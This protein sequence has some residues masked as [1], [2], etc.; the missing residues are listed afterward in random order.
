MNKATSLL[1]RCG[2]ML[3]PLYV[4]CVTA[5]VLPAVAWAQPADAKTTDKPV[6]AAAADAK[7][8]GAS[9]ANKEDETA[10]RPSVYFMPLEGEFGRRISPQSLMRALEDVKKNQPDY[11]ILYF[12]MEWAFG[13]QQINEDGA[14]AEQDSLWITWDNGLSSAT[15]MSTLLSDR[16]RDDKQWKKKPKVV[17]WVNKAM[18]PSAFLVFGFKELY[19]HPDAHHGG[20]GYTET[21]FKGSDE[22]ARQKQISLRL[23]EAKGMGERGCFDGRIVLAMANTSTVMSMTMEGGE[24]KLFMDD[25]GEIL[26]TDDGKEGNR[27]TLEDIKRDRGN[28]VLTLH[29]DTALKLKVSKGTVVSR[30]ELLEQLG[31]IRNSKVIDGKANKIFNEWESELRTAEKE[32]AD[33]MRNYRDVRA[34]KDT[35]SA[36]SEARDRQISLL[37]KAL[38][39]I[40]KYS[41]CLNPRVLFQSVGSGN[42]DQC[43]SYLK[44]QIELL[45][46]MGK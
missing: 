27:D 9:V 20:L 5:M 38:T 39:R 45:R 17:G 31:I 2:A 42:V 41:K 26:L 36:R 28:D 15:E 14:M 8:V 13:G 44:N 37:R 6:V 23:G 40:E 18:G 22:T 29:A 24:P 33:A 11:L 25:T 32:I 10:D 34:E 43:E 3:L 46:Q 30:D 35:P 19:Y 7:P 4:M 12:N 21:M 1:V 16:I